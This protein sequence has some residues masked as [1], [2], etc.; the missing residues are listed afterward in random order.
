MA[1]ELVPLKKKKNQEE[2][3]SSFWYQQKVYLEPL[4]EILGDERNAKR[5]IP[6]ANY[7]DRF[8]I[9]FVY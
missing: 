3:L 9:E 7:S 4:N 1:R 8:I 5:K 2:Y 6:V